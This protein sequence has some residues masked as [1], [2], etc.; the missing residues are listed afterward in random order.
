M[1]FSSYVFQ[2][3]NTDNRADTHECMRNDW[4]LLRMSCVFYSQQLTLLTDD[5][6]DFVI[7]SKVD[8]ISIVTNRL[9]CNA[10]RIQFQRNGFFLS[11]KIK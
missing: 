3:S 7:A 6:V 8:I 9:H 11:D 2:S 10:I 4:K 1:I 5:P